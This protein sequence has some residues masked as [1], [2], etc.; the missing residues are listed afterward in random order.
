MNEP[1]LLKRIR[2]STAAWLCSVCVVVFLLGFLP[3]VRGAFVAA[4]TGASI[5]A[6]AI[7]VL[8]SLREYNLKLQ[9]ETRLTYSTQVESD[10][11]LVQVLTN[12]MNIAHG[13]GGTAVSDKLLDALIPE[14]NR[15]QLGVG[16][17]VE[18]IKHA[19]VVILPVG[20]AA[21]D[22]AIAAVCELGKRHAFLRPIALQALE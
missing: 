12:I 6:V 17:N 2:R 10:I 9:A 14:E 11:K 19:A 21:Q 22:A 3:G 16:N 7:G 8:L 18:A 13:R 1:Q 5:I 4:S 20:S 15:A